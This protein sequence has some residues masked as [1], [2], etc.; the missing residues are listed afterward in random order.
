MCGNRQAACQISDPR[1]ADCLPLPP[2]A[3]RSPMWASATQ[4]GLGGVKCACWACLKGPSLRHT[5]G[6]S[7]HILESLYGC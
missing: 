6:T 3:C 7:L 2:A 5:G 1:R 4:V